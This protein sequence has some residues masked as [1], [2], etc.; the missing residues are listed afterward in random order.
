MTVTMEHIAT[1]KTI[2]EAIEA[3]CAALGLDRDSVSV[4]VLQTPSKGFLFGLGAQDAKVRLT[5]EVQQPDPKPQPAA[6]KPQTP[7]QQPQAP[8]EASDRAAKPQP[9]REASDRAA[10]PQP[11]RE[12]SSEG[13]APVSAPRQQD[14]PAPQKERRQRAKGEPRPQQQAAQRKAEPRAAEAAPQEPARPFEPVS[15]TRAEAFLQEI[16]SILELPVDMSAS[17]DGTVL[18]ISLSGDNMGLLIGRRGE[19]LD[20]LQYLTSLVAVHADDRFSK[21]SLDIENYRAKREE[22]LVSLA[23][24]MADKVVRLQKSVT[25][26][27]MN[28]YERRV[29]HSALQEVEGVETGSIGHEPSR[30]VVI[31]PAGSGGPRSSASGSGGRSRRRRRRPQ[32]PKAPQNTRGGS[33]DG[34]LSEAGAADSD[35]SFAPGQP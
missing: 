12:A 20:A 33:G 25:L 31:S 11:P 1:G 32:G 30:R 26:E 18:R 10:K 13:A 21:V 14:A 35:V 7:K 28:P 24:K 16:F 17:S 19:T 9:P 8:R 15:D 2:E 4:E 6:P 5:Y 27:P 3:G 34:A 23:L 22:V 29:I